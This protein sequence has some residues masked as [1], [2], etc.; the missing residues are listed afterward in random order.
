VTRDTEYANAELQK[1]LAG[2]RPQ[3]RSKYGD[4]VIFSCRNSFNKVRGSTLATPVLVKI[5][6]VHCCF[7]EMRL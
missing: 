3:K 5:D 1:L 2:R 7:S 4:L 6:A